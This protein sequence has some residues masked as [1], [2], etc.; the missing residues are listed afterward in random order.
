MEGS[1]KVIK[2]LMFIFNMMFALSG[3]TL[4]ITGGVIQGVYRQYLDFLGSQFFSAPVLLVVVGCIIFFVTFFGCCGAIKENHCMTVTFSVFLS[5]I[6]LLE[7]GAGIGAYMMRGDV[8]GVV[9]TNMEKGLLNYGKQGFRGVTETWNVVQH[10]MKCCGAQEYRDWSNT[11]F[12]IDG[13]SVPDSCCLSDIEGCGRGILNMTEDQVPKI[14]YPGG[15]LDKFEEV[16]G[17]NV[18]AV[19]GVGVGIAF[20]QFIGIVFACL[21][22][23]TIKKEY[24]TV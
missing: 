21:L 22:A 2:Y 20:L 24:E 11:T 4:V 23:R 3:L 19:G 14:I 7:L 10:E 15:C 5:L 16:I 17:G 8:R 18:A 12:A 6:F 13:A 9:E 1:M